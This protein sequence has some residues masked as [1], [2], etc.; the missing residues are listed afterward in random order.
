MMS[1]DLPS[2][3]RL[4]LAY[5]AQL[6]KS[7]GAPFDM[8]TLENQI[9]Q[10]WSEEQGD[11]QP[12]NSRDW[13]RRL[14]PDGVPKLH[15]VVWDLVVQRVLTFSSFQAQGLVQAQTWKYLRL[16]EYGAEVVREQS[17]SP[18]DPDG[19]L[20]ELS[21]QAP[22]LSQHCGMYVAEALQCFRGGCYLATVVMLGAASEGIVLELF[23]RFAA[24][25][26]AGG[27]PEAESVESKIDKEQS[28]YRKYEM[29]RKHFDELAKPKLPGE[30]S[31]NL[32]LQ[33][34]GVFNLIRYY[35]N[36]AGHP[37]GT[38]I[39]RMSAFTS[40]TL[41]VPYCGRVEQL[42]GWLGANAGVL[43]L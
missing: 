42:I 34:D 28:A 17:W 23:R 16:T 21:V 24:A 2:A 26:R 22:T 15:E 33:F 3:R 43:N 19:Y 1:I 10:W 37:T 38:Q 39:D 32:N 13:A 14:G 8:P 6:S 27:V 11:S 7:P 41:F 31:D 36:D 18:Y 29:F 25:L 12:P 35:R 40:L 5:L 30:L 9:G 20:R 4:V